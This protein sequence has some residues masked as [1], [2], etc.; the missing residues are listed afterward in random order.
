MN[1]GAFFLIS[2]LKVTLM[3]SSDTLIIFILEKINIYLYRY[4]VSILFVLSN[5]GNILSF[6]IFLKK[7][8]R[9]YVCVFYFYVCLAISTCYINSSMLSTIFT[10]GFDIHVENSNV[11]LCKFFYYISYVFATLSPTTLIWA[12]IDRLFISS[13]NTNLRFYSSRRLGYLTTSVNTVCWLIFYSHALVKI[14]IY[15]NVCYYDLDGIYFQFISISTLSIGIIT[16]IILNILV[17]ITFKNVRQIHLIPRQ[18]RQQI[19][20]MHRKD[21]QLLRCLYALDVAHI[22]FTGFIGLYYVYDSV[23]KSSSLSPIHQAIKHFLDGFTLFLC[24]IFYCIDFPIFISISKTFR[25]DVKQIMSTIFYHK[26]RRIP[27]IV[28]RP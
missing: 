27:T 23:T 10:K 6:I 28:I 13:Q 22:F 21:F 4:I 20:P 5:I 24:H 3:S 14:G 17:I 7:S 9:K 2:F 26:L 18:Q 11:I 8:W 15:D 1:I 16:S 12:S 19:R 25:Q